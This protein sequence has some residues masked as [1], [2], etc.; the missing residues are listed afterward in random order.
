MSLADDNIHKMVFSLIPD[1]VPALFDLWIVG[2]KF[3]QDIAGSLEQT[4]YR[5]KQGHNDNY[6]ELPL[7]MLEYFNVRQFYL[8][9]PTTD[10]AISRILNSI[11]HAVQVRKTLPRFLLCILDKD[12]IESDLEAENEDANII[13]P[14]LVN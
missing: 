10:H 4:K 5:V 13:L 14:R 3:L 1:D 7:Y 8:E 9:S 2:D 6:E 12:I 11:A